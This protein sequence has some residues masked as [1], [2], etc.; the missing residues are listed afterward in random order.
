MPGE[1]PEEVL[2]D[3]LKGSFTGATAALASV[4]QGSSKTGAICGY[5]PTGHSWAV[6]ESVG[7]Q[8]GAGDP[9]AG[10]FAYHPVSGGS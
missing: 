9:F 5:Q 8:Q 1:R 7:R 6:A 10:L 4:E 2:Q 3:Y